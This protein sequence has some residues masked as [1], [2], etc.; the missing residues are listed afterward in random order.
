[1][2]L[3]YVVVLG[4]DIPSLLCFRSKG[5]IKVK[6]RTELMKRVPKHDEFDAQ[7]KQTRMEAS[8]PMYLVRYE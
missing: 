7:K 4:G 1:M 5:V 3:L 6:E 2:S 8:K